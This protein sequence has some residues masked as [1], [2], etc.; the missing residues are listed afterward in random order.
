MKLNVNYYN[1]RL[2]T[3]TMN[4]FLKI[5]VLTFLKNVI[6]SEGTGILSQHLYSTLKRARYL[7]PFQTLLIYLRK[8]IPY[9]KDVILILIL[10]SQAKLYGFFYLK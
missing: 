5:M 7:L 3:C 10:I 8:R 1:I 2:G 4:V 6:F 9:Y